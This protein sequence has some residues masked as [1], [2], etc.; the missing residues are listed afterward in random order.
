MKKT[1]P[2]SKIVYIFTISFIY[3]TW[4]NLKIL[5]VNEPRIYN[6]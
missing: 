5:S 2:V 6:F 1:K 3:G 4:K